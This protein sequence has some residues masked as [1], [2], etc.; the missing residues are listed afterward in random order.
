[1]SDPHEPQR[2]H[3]WQFLNPAFDPFRMLSVDLGPDHERP[4]LLVAF[5]RMITMPDTD[6]T[7]SPFQGT[8]ATLRMLDAAGDVLNE[9]HLTWKDQELRP[10]VR[11]DYQ[12]AEPVVQI[13]KLGGVVMT[14]I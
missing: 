9:Y 4:G 7:A 2:Q 1:M 10:F 11:L 6:L 12:S 13:V 14:R 5:L 8:E 3:R